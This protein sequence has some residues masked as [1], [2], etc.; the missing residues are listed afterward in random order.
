LPYLT[1]FDACRPKIVT[2]ILQKDFKS[3]LTLFADGLCVIL[4]EQRFSQ[5]NFTEN[6]PKKQRI[7]ATV[8]DFCVFAL[9]AVL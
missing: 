9:L 7:S 2:E 1:D 4:Q 6:K 8:A 5:E 3:F